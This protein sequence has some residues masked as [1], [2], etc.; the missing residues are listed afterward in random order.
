[1]SP[2]PQ[3]PAGGQYHQDDAYYHDDDD[4]DDFPSTNPGEN[5]LERPLL[6]QHDDHN[7]V[8]TFPPHRPSSAASDTSIFD[9]PV[10]S[11][12]VPWPE[13]L[14]ALYAEY[15]RKGQD[16]W[17]SMSTVQRAAAV[18]ALVIVGALGIAVLLL[19][20]RLMHWLVPKAEQWEKSGTAYAVI[21]LM[22]FT[23]SFP[24]LIG[25]A[26]IGT[27]SGFIFGVWRGYA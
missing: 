25:W 21:G 26:T 19:S 16:T 22:T 8:P 11:D 20:K 24:P 5:Y 9:L 14:R 13:R 27:C 6:P 15:V 2:S 1:M 4:D 10:T 3:D 12:N 7:L 17:D 23:V 18:V